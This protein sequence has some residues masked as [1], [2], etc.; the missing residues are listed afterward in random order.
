MRQATAFSIGRKARDENVYRIALKASASALALGGLLAAQVAHA[1][2]TSADEGDD[3]EEVASG[4][5]EIVVR[6]IRQSLESAQ[7]IKRNA[8]TVVDVITAEDIGA[9]PDRSVTEALQRV[10]GVAINRFAGSNDPDHFSVEGSGVV[11][12]G[13]NFV[14][15]EFNGRTAFVA[16]VGGQALNFADVP[17]ELL[18]SVVI[19]KNATAD[20]I[21]GG[22]AGTVNLN[23]RKPFDNNGL[24]IAFS[25]EANYGD[26]REE[27]TP[28]VSGLISNTWDT[29]SGRFGL[30]ISGS[31]SRIK[32]RADGLQITNFQTRDNVLAEKAFAG[33]AQVCRNPLPGTADSRTL[34]PGGSVCGTAQGPGADGFADYADV[35]YAPIGGQFR[36]Q[37][38]DRKRD[39]IAVSAQWESN[40]ERTRLTAEF[41][42]SHSTN[43]WGEYTFET[44]P[45]SS[46]YNTYPLGCNQNSNG[47]AERVPDGRGGFMD[48]DPTTRGECPV[49]GFQDYIYDSNNLFQSGYITRPS[50]GWRGNDAAGGFVPAGG[51][52]QQIARRQVDEETTNTDYSLHLSHQLTD[53]LTIDL[54]AQYAESRKEN[55]DVSLFGSTFADQE[56]DLTGNLPMVIPHKPNFL[57]YSWAGDNAELA[58]QSDAEYFMDPRS[59]FWRAAMDHIEDSQ[60]DQFAFRA[61]MQYDF[62]DDSFLRY[63][64]VGARYSGADQTV[65][66]TTYNWGVLSE[67]WSGTPVS[68]DEFGTDQQTFYDFPDFFRGQAPGP[69]GAFYYAGDLTGD[70][71]GFQAFGL[72]VNQEWQNQG[73]SAGWVPLAQRSG[74]IDGTPYLPSDIQ[75]IRQDD[76]AIYGMLSFGDQYEPIFGDVRLGGN[77]GLRYVS[78][79]IS[80]PGIY[81][82]GGRQNLGVQNPFDERCGDPVQ[83]P[84][85]Q[86]VSPGGV[87]ALGEDAY[88]NL[89]ELAIQPDINVPSKTTYDFLLPSANL[90]FGIG[91]DVIFRL[92]AS[93]V[94]TRPDNAFL[95]NFLNVSIDTNSGAL[96]AQAGNPGIKPATAWQFDASLEW[97]FAPVGSITL[98]G[99]YKSVSDFFFQRVRVENFT[100]GD[101]SVDILTRGPDNFDEKGKIKGFELAYQQTYDFLPA[102]FDGLGIAANYT[103]IDSEGLPNTFLN[104]GNLANNTVESPSTIAPGNLPLEQLSKHNVN[105]T[106]FYEKGPISMRAAYN[107]RSRFLLTASDVIFPF[108]SIFNE[109]TGQLDASIFFNLTDNVRVGVQGVNLTNEVTETTQAFTGDPDLLAPRSFFMNDRRFSF[110]VRGNF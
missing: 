52:Q 57:S 73:G 103:Y 17:S 10:P 50:D 67:V 81:S 72:G 44:Q 104:G 86:L 28:T 54:D 8:D 37:E 46:E 51:M 74:A 11:I 90:K 34:P 2:D 109:P 53:R 76:Y 19:S 41:I 79:T 13:L 56:L 22:L 16:G 39:G 3:Q 88:N 87:C 24:K 25:G 61:D 38:F 101:Q 82:L 89:R 108:Y 69:V 100:F 31:Y 107:W 5:P 105:A 102:P 83:T 21:E 78:T 92:A 29:D 91:E 68:F 58:G 71:E 63:A 106:V 48:G 42:R 49:G 96:F 80:S 45:D 43:E 70:Y 6:G 94:L 62:P 14:R 32:S 59:Q 30:L 36:T 65:R 7:N 85:G 95:R 93:R 40:D 1:Q 26:F 9:L 77:I 66:Y 75:R 64:K 55:L 12:R 98:N 4:S 35:R 47:P 97:Y 60:G 33:G 84:T 110:I 15:S 18:G 20:L 99:F 23:T 27:W